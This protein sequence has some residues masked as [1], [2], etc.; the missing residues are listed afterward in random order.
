VRGVRQFVSDRWVLDDWQGWHPRLFEWRFRHTPGG[1]AIRAGEE[2]AVLRLLAQVLHSGDRVLEIGSGTGHYTVIL[3]RRGAAVT[4]VD[5]SPRMRRH[6]AARLQREA[7][8]QVDVRAGRLPERLDSLG[9]FA[10]VVSVGAL[11]YVRDLPAALAAMTGPLGDRG[12]LIFTVPPDTAAGRR[13]AFGERLIR[14]GVFVRSDEEVR[15]ALA[16]IG[17]TLRLADT[18]RGSTRVMYAFA[19]PRPE[20]LSSGSEHRDRLPAQRPEGDSTRKGG[21]DRG[22]S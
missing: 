13:Y 7:I 11:N 22:R 10:G 9:R 17:Y 2:E 8:D 4:A 21:V 6:L 3:A 16:A 18:P 14:K 5:A 20:G 1:R 15:S 19:S 12:W